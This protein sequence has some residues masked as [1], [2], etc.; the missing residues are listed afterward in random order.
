MTAN[1]ANPHYESVSFVQFIII[2]LIRF[3][4]KRPIIHPSKKVKGKWSRIPGVELYL[5]DSKER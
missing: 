3:E 2:R 1:E 4:F 5:E